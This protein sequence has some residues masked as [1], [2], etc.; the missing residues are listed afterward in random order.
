MY[1]M[2][3]IIWCII[4]AA[5]ANAVRLPEYHLMACNKNVPSVIAYR[6]KRGTKKGFTAM[7]RAFWLSLIDPGNEE[8]LLQ[9]KNAKSKE[10]IDKK[11]GT[12][13]T[14]SRWFGR[15]K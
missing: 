10:R 14:K 7:L 11:R 2:G 12:T 3:V 9:S 8:G 5:M 1:G 15:T 13:R 6:P 4:V